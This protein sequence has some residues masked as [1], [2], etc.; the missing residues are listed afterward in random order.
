M[1]L[2]VMAIVAAV[3]YL[4]LSLLPEQILWFKFLQ[5]FVT[6]FA[7]ITLVPLLIKKLRI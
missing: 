3:P 1:R 4:L 2:L 5:Y 6:I 7:A